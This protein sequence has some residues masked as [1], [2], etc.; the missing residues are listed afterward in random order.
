LLSSQCLIEGNHL[1]MSG[2]RTFV[3]TFTNYIASGVQDNRTDL[4]VHALGGA[5]KGKLKCAIHRVLNG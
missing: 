5:Q 4:G 3:K 2:A 1:G